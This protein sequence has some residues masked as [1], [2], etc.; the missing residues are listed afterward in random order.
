MDP[1]PYEV[2]RITIMSESTVAS[3]AE[4]HKKMDI[5][6]V[7]LNM[8]NK[9]ILTAERAFRWFFLQLTFTFYIAAGSQIMFFPS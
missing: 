5:I 9:L 7:A 3:G 1:N 8:Y 4:G 6:S 2:R